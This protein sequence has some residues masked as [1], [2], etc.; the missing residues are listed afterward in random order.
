LTYVLG[1]MMS[2]LV[3]SKTEDSV[4]CE[5]VDGG[6]LKSRRH[7]NVRGKSA[8]LPSI[9]GLTLNHHLHYLL[10]NISFLFPYYFILFSF[11]WVLISQM[12]MV[13]Y[14]V[15]AADK[16]WDDI[17]FG[18][19]NKVDFYAVSFVKDAQVVHELKNYLQSNI[20]INMFVIFFFNIV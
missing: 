17:K 4:K 1:G 6:E 19:E 13:A 15:L 10:S 9:T 14:M 7:L 18:V 8:T 11:V 16:D 5:V 20:C 12:D 3:K 2:L